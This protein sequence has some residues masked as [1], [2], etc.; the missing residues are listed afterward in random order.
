MR[1]DGERSAFR[2]LAKGANLGSAANTRRVLLKDA[3]HMVHTDA[4][5]KL[6]ALLRGFIEQLVG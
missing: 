3:G 1:V 4:P 5:E 2:A 6:A